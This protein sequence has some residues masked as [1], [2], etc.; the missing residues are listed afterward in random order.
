[1]IR[2]LIV[3]VIAVLLLGG[4][5]AYSQFRPQPNHVSG[6]IEADEI[7]LGSRVGGRVQAVRVQEGQRV[8]PGQVLVELEPYDLLERENEAIETLAARD[9]EYRLLA[10]PLREEEIA[11]AKARYDQFKARLDLLEAPPRKQ[12][13]EAA[14]GRLRVAQAELKLAQ[15]NYERLTELFQKNA[16]S[17]QDLD[18][19]S[20]QL[21]AAQATVV[22]RNEE[23]DLIQAGAR[24]QEKEEARARVEEAKQ[25][26]QLAR[27]GNREE[28]IQQAKA[29]RDAAKAALDAIRQQKKELTIT[30]PVDGVVEALDLQPGDLAPAGAPVLS[31]MD[32]HHLWVRAYVPQN[33]VGLRVGQKLRVTADSLGDKSFVGE[34]IFIARQA[35]FTPSNVQTPEERSKQVFRIKVAL[36]QGLKELRPGMTVDVGLEPVDESQ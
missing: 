3:I 7:R 12:E 15:R 5:I 33:R 21:E 36:K 1:M 34:I 8:T 23:L 2:R 14:R 29:A 9:A 19:A 6:F 24:E 32:D 28:Q 26:W 18:E 27:K 10:A 13:L 30:S 17:R 31:V 25:A 20:E 35:E 22:V 11:Q 16:I 4:L